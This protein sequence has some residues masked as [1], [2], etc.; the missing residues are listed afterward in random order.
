MGLIF[1]VNILVILGIFTM[2]W[3]SVKL[4]PTLWILSALSPIS[5]FIMNKGLIVADCNI[6]EVVKGNVI[7]RGKE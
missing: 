6:P 5:L 4:I 7:K 1:L 2:F 3:C